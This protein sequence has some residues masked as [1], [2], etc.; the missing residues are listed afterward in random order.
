MDRYSA[1]AGDYPQAPGVCGVNQS[2]AACDYAAERMLAGHKV[3]EKELHGLFNISDYSAAAAIRYG[4][5]ESSA[6][7]VPAPKTFK[8]SIGTGAPKRGRPPVSTGA[9]K[10]A[11]DADRWAAS[12]QRTKG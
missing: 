6:A 5:E 8:P 7:Y 3:T 12:L 1:G 2:D 10:A 9:R 4:Q 11:E